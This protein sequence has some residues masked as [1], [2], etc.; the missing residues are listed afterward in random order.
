MVIDLSLSRLTGR[1]GATLNGI[2]HSGLVLVGNLI[3][4]RVHRVDCVNGDRSGYRAAQRIGA[5]R[6]PV[7]HVLRA[8]AASDRHR[9]WISAYC[10]RIR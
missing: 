7:I 6:Q 4:I 10:V 8:V 9:Q 5:F 2:V 1:P 3:L